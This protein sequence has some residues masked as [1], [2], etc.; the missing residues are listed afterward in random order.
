M[1]L[2]TDSLYKTRT[3]AANENESQGFKMVLI[4]ESFNKVIF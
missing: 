3:K 4:I 2:L 1:K